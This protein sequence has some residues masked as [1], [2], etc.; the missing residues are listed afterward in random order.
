MQFPVLD[1]SALTFS[2][3]FYGALAVGLSIDE[4]VGAG[5]VAVAGAGDA[6]GGP[7]RRLYLR[8]PDGI[9]FSEFMSDP[10]LDGPR[11]KALSRSTLRVRRSMFG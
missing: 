10:A 5:R 11:V 4:A 2:E 3:H 1:R 6:R 7:P 9:I 8:S